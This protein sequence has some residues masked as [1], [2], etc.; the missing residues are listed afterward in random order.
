MAEYKFPMTLNTRF[1]NK[2]EELNNKYGDELM[3]I[4]G[5]SPSQLDTCDFFKGFLNTS[6]VADATIDDNANVT[7]R[8]ICTMLNESQKPF[9]KLLSRN[10]IYSQMSKEFG[11]EVADEFLESA[12]NGELYEHDSHSSS[13]MPYCFA[14]SVEPIVE[15]GL[16][17]IGEMK[18]ER[19]KHWDTFNHHILEFISYATNM[20]S[21]AVGI[22]DYLIYAYYFYKI[23][24][25]DMTHD[26]QTKYRNQKFQE[27]IFNLN[28]PYLKSGVQSAYTNISILDIDHILK[29]F[30]NKKY[31]DGT[32]IT[33]YLEELFEFQ[34]SFLEYATDLRKKKWYT[35]PVISASLVFRDGEYVDEDTAKMVVKHNYTHGFNEVNIMNVEEVTSLA[36]CCFDKNQKI[37]TKNPLGGVVCET[38]ESFYNKSYKY[39]QNGSIFHNGSWAKGQIVKTQSNTLYKISTSNKKEILVTPDHLN[40]SINGDIRSDKLTTNDYLLFNTKELGTYPEADLGLT[41]EQGVLIGS[42]LGDGSIE[43]KQENHKP[44]IQLSLNETKYIKLLPI[45]N[46]VIKQLNID[47]EV[48]LHAEYN[49]VYPVAIASYELKDF[50]K[51]WTSGNYSQ[52]KELNLNC[53]I[54]SLEF[55]K[56]ILDGYYITDGGNSNRIYTTSK[57]MTEQLE[58]L[59]TSLGMHSIIDCSD[60]TDEPIVIRGEEYKRNYPVY[61]IRWYNPKHKRNMKNIFKTINNSIYFKINSIEKIENT[62]KDVYCFTMDNKEE[63]YF[64]LPNGIITHNCRLVSDKKKIQDTK[65]IFNSIGGS[66]LNVGSTKVVTLNLSRLSMENYDNYD[67]FIEVIKNK[68]KLI[69]KYHYA[70]REILKELINNGLLP[71][72]SHN[73]MNLEDQFATVGINGIFEAI[74]IF[75]GLNYDSSGCYYNDLGFKIAKDI[76][77]TIIKENENTINEYGFLSNSEI[78]P[79]E[80][81][82]IKSNKKDRLVL[83]NRKV[84]QL[85]GKDYNIYGN[86]WIPL[87]EH[88]SLYNRIESAKLD[89]Y[90]DGGSILHVSMGEDFDTFE[91]AWDFA[92]Q[93]ARKGVKYYSKVSL[94]DICEKDHSFFGDVCPICGGKSVTKGIKIVGY[95]VKQDSYKQ[96]RKLELSQRQFYNKNSME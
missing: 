73:M 16:F 1:K 3:K 53:L 20:Q 9:T 38:F 80:S 93:L 40:P 6:T 37:I 92:L 27:F 74:K 94:I 71:L 64:T 77:D 75:N 55:R 76:L 95:M 84:N 47:T 52:E 78:I 72:Y 28:Q 62:N 51:T 41:Y 34:S 46:K 91:E 96:E 29:F 88:A 44:V 31:P 45:L 43:Q 24:T 81:S 42:Y 82:A 22:P 49:N 19:P 17:F 2:V 65:K 14:F 25:A 35:F 89:K 50:I 66:D 11:S 85:L 15:K 23:D 7:G 63:P 33:D 57:K 58:A 86:Q 12:V 79:G 32:L 54:Q 39:K 61:C 30:G 10:K 18:A 48:K 59:I 26:K 67:N 90:C 60:R 87:K 68:V 13:Y 21:G 4:E 36:S 69:H 56:G 70:H 8:N 83:G 5:M